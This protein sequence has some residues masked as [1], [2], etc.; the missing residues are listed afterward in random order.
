MKKIGVLMLGACLSLPL[1]AQD[2][3]VDEAPAMTD[4]AMPAE[5]MAASED[6]MAAEPAPTEEAAPA[7]DAAPAEEVASEAPAEEAV[8]EDV[9]AEA[10][11]EEMAPAEAMAAESAPAEEAPMED[12][13]ASEA[14]PVEEAAPAEEVASEEAASEEAPAE[15]TESED[16]GTPFHL[17]GGI[18]MAHLTLSLS[19]P[20]LRGNGAG[21]YGGDD[22]QSDFYRARIGTRIF[23]VIGLELHV[24]QADSD[25]TEN[26]EVEVSQYYGVYAVPTGTLFDVIEVSAPIGYSMLS[27]QRGTTEEDFDG[28][29]FGLNF[30]I[31][32]FVTEGGT[33]LR[34]GGGGTVY[35]A[36]RKS[37]T[38]GYH[39]GIRLDFQL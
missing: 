4:E 6:A 29:S 17:Y 16:A 23:E 19:D 35:Q 1:W 18:D 11:A 30:E 37:R 39:A 3:A 26:G 36:D 13:A 24:G 2:A 33:G 31:P 7:E 22:F 34:I 10:P 12:A 9:A 15:E 27:L 25:G 14:A 28:V 32:V 20:T 21:G 38:Y 8:S 5:D